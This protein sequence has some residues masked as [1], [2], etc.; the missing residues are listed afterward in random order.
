MLIADVAV[1]QQATETSSSGDLFSSANARRL[2]NL[3]VSARFPRRRPRLLFDSKTTTRT[4]DEDERF[5]CGPTALLI[6]QQ[7]ECFVRCDAFFSAEGIQRDQKCTTGDVGTR[8]LQQSA[9]GFDG[10]A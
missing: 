10:S 3:L 2:A 8:P 5:V 1:R 9:T 4:K 6:V 7:T